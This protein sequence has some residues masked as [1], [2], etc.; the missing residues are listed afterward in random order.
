MPGSAPPET[1]AAPER[2]D[3]GPAADSQSAPTSKAPIVVPKQRH[4]HGQGSQS[5]AHGK[6]GADLKHATAK[7]ATAKE[8]NAKDATAKDATEKD[9]AR[10]GKGGDGDDDGTDP[11]GGGGSRGPAPAMPAGR[12]RARTRA[13]ESRASFVSHQGTAGDTRPATKGSGVRVGEPVQAVPQATPYPD[14]PAEEGST[15]ES[16]ITSAVSADAQAED[17]PGPLALAASAARVAAE[18]RIKAAMQRTSPAATQDRH[19]SLER[20]YPKA[21]AAAVQAVA[22]GPDVASGALPRISDEPLEFGYEDEDDA[23]VAFAWGGPAFA[24]RPGGRP[25]V[26]PLRPRQ[27]DADYDDEDLDL[28]ADERSEH[29]PSGYVRRNRITRG[30]SIPRLSRAKRP[31]A[32]PGL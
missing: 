24:A 4:E 18:A 13:G 29:S 8:A 26:V 25:E 31:G 16:G 15:I 23:D 6:A 27:D 22:A 1:T 2:Q 14:P 9:K 7:D 5:E 11:G 17:Y 3:T 19:V 30:Y 32:V 12:N 20:A 21:S 28:A 10:D